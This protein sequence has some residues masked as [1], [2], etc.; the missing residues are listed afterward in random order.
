MKWIPNYKQPIVETK[1]NQI[2]QLICAAT[3]G[4]IV[5]LDTESTLNNGGNKLSL[6][7]NQNIIKHNHDLIINATEI[8]TGMTFE[9]IQMNDTKNYIQQLKF[10]ETLQYNYNED[11]WL[12]LEK[13]MMYHL[14][15]IPCWIYRSNDNGKV[16][17]YHPQR[18]I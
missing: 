6:K 8:D 15:N 7:R 16:Y 2:F 11:W 1:L 14:R 12:L 3:I 5:N 4:V 10:I 9:S 13:K 17:W 18:D